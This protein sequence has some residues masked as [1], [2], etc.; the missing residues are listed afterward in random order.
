MADLETELDPETAALLE[1][2]GF[3]S[4]LFD[5]LR[6]R[7][8]D[9]QA[10]AE[11]NALQGAIEPPVEG[12]VV[13]LPAPGSDERERLAVLGRQAIAAGQV[14]C[15]VLAGGMATRFGGVVKAGVDA[16]PGHSFAALKL[17]QIDAEARR[18]GGAVP[19]YLMSSFATHSEVTELGERY[20][21]EAAP[22]HT[23]PQ[24]I[25]LR[26]APDGKL[27]RDGDG[28]LS[29]YAPG[30]GDLTF[31]LRASGML[32]RFRQRGGRILY[33]SNVDNLAATLDPAVIG[34]HLDQGQAVTVEVVG[35]EDDAGGAPARVDGK[36]Q[37]VE[38][39]RFPAD[40]D[41]ESIPVFNTNSFVL[42]AEAIDR[43]FDLTWFAVNKK[44]KGEPAV[45]FEHL[46]GEL[47]ALLST[48]C[49]KVDRGG[50]DGRFQP[51]KDP[52][53]LAGRVGEIEAIMKARGGL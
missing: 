39:F 43:D 44:V 30:H 1:R 15:V 17:R 41:Q 36:L 5:S 6:T 35:K 25:S 16:L 32:E 28:A 49:L 7:L 33:M 8:V 14:G 13:A 27:F 37:I 26:L 11:H 38:A 9:G 23:F 34:A 42:D 2:Y 19:T 10:T 45:Q 3:D 22:V 40:F 21:T 24:L 51:A 29:P 46:V 18:C 20:S 48:A 47:T 12:D 53:E 52:E 4:T 50:L 31:A